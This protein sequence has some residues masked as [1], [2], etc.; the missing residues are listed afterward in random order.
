MKPGAGKRKGGEREFWARVGVSTPDQCWPWLKA[1]SNTGHGVVWHE[2][3]LAHAHRIAWAF[4]RGKTPG[5]WCIRHRCDNPACCNPTHLFRGTQQQNMQEAVRRERLP[6]WNDVPKPWVQGS[7]NHNAKLTDGKVR[8]ARK[9]VLGGQLTLT[10]ACCYLNVSP[11]TLS[12]AVNG[13][14]WRHLA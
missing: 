5:K 14:T 12:V 8:W 13:K 6:D 10:V 4:D 7:K 9:M 11:S 1:C 2:G 3:K